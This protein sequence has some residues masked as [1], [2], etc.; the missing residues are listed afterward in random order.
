V[1]VDTSEFPNWNIWGA[2]SSVIDTIIGQSGRIL[3]NLSNGG[4]SD[5]ALSTGLHHLATLNF[6]FLDVGGFVF[7]TCFFPPIFHGASYVD[8]S[9]VE[10]ILRWTECELQSYYQTPHITVS[11][12]S[13]HFIIQEQGIVVESLWVQNHG[14]TLVVSDISHSSSWISIDTTNF[15]L[16]PLDTQIALVTASGVGLTPGLYVDTVLIHSNDPDDPV[17]AVPVSLIKELTDD[18][19]LSSD[20]SGEPI[21]IDLELT[22]LDTFEFHLMLRNYSDTAHAVV[23]PICYDANGLYLDSYEFDVSTFPE[24]S[25]WNFSIE[26]TIIADSGKLSFYAWTT[27]S[28]IGI[29]NGLENHRI[30]TADFVVTDIT[31]GIIDTC[32]YSGHGSLSFYNVPH[33][34]F[35]HPHWQPVSV[36]SLGEICGDV[37]GNG[38]ITTGD[39]FMLL[40]YFGSGPQP[41]S[42]WAANV[43][44]DGALTTGDGFLLL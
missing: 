22:Y 27:L 24:P 29:P 43:N 15:I 10:H 39:A 37:N 12:D 4:N 3:V 31:D 20:P 42:C 1:V 21:L 23:F 19:W 35:Y 40:N 18:A 16:S 44:G 17:F 33:G 38:T 32:Y 25:S 6:T 13:L 28:D 41:V 7:D 26:D 8:T 30:A 11:P 9:D 36:H 2:N 14:D 5:Y 34:T